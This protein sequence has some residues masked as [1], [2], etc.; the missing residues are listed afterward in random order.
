MDKLVTFGFVNCNRLHYLKACVK[1]L[2]A[3]TED[4]PNKEF[5]IVDNASLEEGTEEFLKEAESY[6]G[7]P[8][9]QRVHVVRR[10]RR[11]P[12]NEFAAG[13][14][15][16]IANA[17]GEYIAPLQGDMQFVLKGKWLRECV[18]FLNK[19]AGQATCVMLDA[20][21][22]VTNKRH[23]FLQVEF[24]S[25]LDF[26]AVATR[27]PM[28]TAGDVLYPRQVLDQFAPWS[29]QNTEHEGS[30]DSETE[31]L[32]RVKAFVQKAQIPL[33][34]IQPSRPAAVAI[35]TD[36]RGTNA[37][38]RGNRRYGDYWGPKRGDYYYS[39]I[40]F[41]ETKPSFTSGRVESE[42][43]PEGIESV[44]R[45][46]GFSKFVDKNGDWLK[47]PIRPETAKPHEWVELGYDYLEPKKTYV[48]DWLEE[49]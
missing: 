22:N 17:H 27:S 29:T 48:D 21:R 18:N 31:M 7:R 2:L 40:D 37:R 28:A 45:P 9:V 38:I 43:R 14:N 15:T 47:N 35:Y 49:D 19:Y 26:Y 34:T 8:D 20:Q 30:Q 4:Y 41:D 3:C 36:R 33:Y 1:S 13:L 24:D 44:A 12:A 11:D 10:S 25:E 42:R 32:N 46:I 16:I 6:A 5:I 39:F 23:K